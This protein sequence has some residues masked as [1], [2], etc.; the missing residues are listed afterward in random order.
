[1]HKSHFSIGNASEL[2][3]C[4]IFHC[5]ESFWIF[6]S[7]KQHSYSVLDFLVNVEK[8]QLFCIAYRSYS[9]YFTLLNPNIVWLGKGKFECQSIGASKLKGQFSRYIPVHLP[10]NAKTLGPPMPHKSN[11]R[12]PNGKGT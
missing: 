6:L 12:S 8:K 1:M 4:W 10:E 2:Y 7:V 9:L 11:H 3:S 5:D